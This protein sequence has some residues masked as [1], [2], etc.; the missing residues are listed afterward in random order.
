MLDSIAQLSARLHSYD[1]PDVPPSAAPRIGPDGEMVEQPIPLPPATLTERVAAYEAS[2]PRSPLLRR[3]ARALLAAEYAA[4]LEKGPW[5]DLYAAERTAKG[6]VE[7]AA[8]LQAEWALQ[9]EINVHELRETRER[10]LLLDNEAR[11]AGF[12]GSLAYKARLLEMERHRLEDAKMHARREKTRLFNEA[13]SSARERA[14]RRVPDAPKLTNLQAVFLS[15]ASR[16]KRGLAS[17]SSLA[18]SSSAASLQITEQSQHASSA[19]PQN[20]T[21]FPPPQQQ[22]PL[23]LVDP[24]QL[25]DAATGVP[26]SP[27]AVSREWGPTMTSTAAAL[28]SSSA[29]TAPVVPLGRS[30]HAPSRDA[31]ERALRADYAA[32]QQERL[33]REKALL[34]MEAHVHAQR[35]AQQKRQWEAEAAERRREEEVERSLAESKRD[36]ATMKALLT[37]AFGDDDDDGDEGGEGEQQLGKQ[38]GKTAS[39]ASASR[40]SSSAS[41][42]SSSHQRREKLMDSMAPL[43]RSKTRPPTTIGRSVHWSNHA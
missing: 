21:L 39:D 27:S 10:Q 16:N 12:A 34:N 36:K 41:T 32:L 20:N 28:P 18:P 43:A 13:Q 26:K 7:R 22:P 9:H 24:T 1:L 4:Q 15:P 40:S 30:V 8:A 2:L 31:L 11:V 5:R 42:S 37:E 35:H 33:E 19:A 3:E 23:P 14:L 17:S 6:N 25:V 29:A 38:S